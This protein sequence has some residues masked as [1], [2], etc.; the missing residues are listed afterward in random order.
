MAII[1]CFHLLFKFAICGF[2]LS[3]CRFRSVSSQDLSERW[4][5]SLLNGDF[6]TVCDVFQD[7]VEVASAGEATGVEGEVGAEEE[8]GEGM[9]GEAVGSV[10]AA[11][12][13]AVAGAAVVDE[14]AE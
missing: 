2:F 8:G 9:E 7:V 13:L 3:D 10:A 12:V 4:F 14:E 11:E 5:L 1:W 6:S